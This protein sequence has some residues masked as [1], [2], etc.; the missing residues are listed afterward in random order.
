MKQWWIGALAICLIALVLWAVLLVVDPRHAP[1]GSVRVE[2][3]FRHLS[4][5]QLQ[6]VVAAQV[7]H[8]FFRVDLEAVR[9]AA[10]ALPWVE[11][12]A[13]RRVWPDALHLL[14]RER[15][16]E[17]RWAAG[18]LV[19]AGG[20]H[21]EPPGKAGPADLPVLQGPPWSTALMLRRLQ[22]FNEWLSPLQDPVTR[23]VMDARRAWRVWLASGTAIELGRQPV[24]QK[25]RRFADVFPAV[26]ASRGQEAR[27]VDL[28]YPNGFAV[29]W[30]EEPERT[31]DLR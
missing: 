20:V 30:D 18:G 19:D 27:R 13:V 21:F 22:A 29:R 12:A 26:L 23:V 1:V 15:Q 3:E 11:D 8:G 16:P 5:E 10:L 4:R 28:R 2:G 24:E 6:R 14:V 7:R 17:A 9:G 31:T 25:M